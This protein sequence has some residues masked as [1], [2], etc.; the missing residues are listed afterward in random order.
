[1]VHLDLKPEN[2]LMDA[3]MMPKIADF[4]L[5][6]I[7]G[8]QQSRIVTNNSVGS[9]GYMAP[10]YLIQG[11]VSMKADI[12][13]LGVIII[14][15]ITGRR[16]Y[17]YFQLDSP[18]ST[19]TSCQY[20]TEK[21]LGSWRN[22]FECTSKCILVEKYNQQVEQCIAMALKCVYPGMEKRPTVKD[23]IQMLNALDQMEA[24]EE[25]PS[26]MQC[27][28]KSLVPNTTVSKDLTSHSITKDMSNNETDGKVRKAKKSESGMPPTPHSESSTSNQNHQEDAKESSKPQEASDTTIETEV[29]PGS[30][31][32]I[33]IY[34]FV[35]QFPFEPNKLN[36]CSLDLT[37]NTSEEVVFGLNKRSNDQMCFLKNLPVYGILAPKSTC[38]L[39][40]TTNKLETLPIERNTNLII[41]YSIIGA[42]TRGARYTCNEHFQEAIELGDTV[43]EVTLKAVCAPHVETTFEQAI[44]PLTKVISVDDTEWITSID[45]NQSETLIVAGHKF[46]H[47]HIWNYDTKK[48]VGSF[49]V[50]GGEVRCVK[51]ISR[52]RWFLVG[53]NNGFI[54]VYDY[55]N[56]IQKVTSFQV[57]YW[58]GVASLA[59]HPTKPY[60][61]S[62]SN[63]NTKLWDWDQDWKCIQ[64]FVGCSE[65]ISVVAFNPE[66]TD[67]FVGACIDLKVWSLDSPEPKYTLA[68]HMRTASSL[69]FFTCDGRRYLISGSADGTA[70]ICDMQKRK[71]VHALKTPDS[72]AVTSV[73]SHP[74]H[75]L[76][77]TGTTSGAVYFWSFTSFR[78]KRMLCIDSP[79]AV[80]G[81]ACLMGSGRVVVAHR[82]TLS[83]IE[84]SD[85]EQGDSSGNNKNSILSAD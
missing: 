16:D 77:V 73:V 11:I 18:Q 65:D 68:K 46:G 31:V 45:A 56:K 70:L 64:T 20:F 74:S 24:C 84:I 26:E 17:P 1:M 47:V 13:S 22:K 23:I 62:A 21:V 83:V 82:D 4:G 40:L 2:I 61:L 79:S 10:E 59:V 42:Y 49:D 57:A 25:L 3:T 50:P 32:I 34:P 6:R 81:L 66:D 14:E 15:I 36:L 63:K 55:E 37:N 60:V 80:Q 76:L 67:S 52:K 27:N 7:F 12:F 9:R 69:D 72:S 51:F 30:S 8:D 38:T 33:D 53:S 75:P 19:I 85:E 29:V 35:L 78:V 44:P 43:H 71:R 39:V 41:Q 5:S 54:H 48:S 28:D 58:G